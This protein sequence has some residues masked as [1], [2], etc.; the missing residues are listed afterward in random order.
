MLI[1]IVKRIVAE[2]GEQVLF[3]SK[4]V[5]AFFTDIAGDE[6][7]PLKR[8]FIGCLEHG[9]V[10]I[11]KDAPIMERADRKGQ[12]AKI[13]RAEEGFDIKICREAINI[14]C[15]VLFASVPVPAKKTA[16]K[17]AQKAPPSLTP[18]L[19]PDQEQQILDSMTPE[20]SGGITIIELGCG[21]VLALIAIYLFGWSA[22]LA[23]V[24][25]VIVLGMI[26]SRK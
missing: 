17:R 14:L 16:K 21:G 13:L 18:P 22:L 6:P 12:L 10:R 9:F 19:P 7:K 20:P 11:L 15:E 5:N 1:D 2:N 24:I 3:D 8:A 23:I 4:R 26:G 25:I